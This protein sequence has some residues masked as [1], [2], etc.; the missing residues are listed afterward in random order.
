MS[1]RRASCVPCPREK[2]GK[3]GGKL[4]EGDMHTGVLELVVDALCESGRQRS[5][6]GAIQRQNHIMHTWYFGYN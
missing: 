6:D 1:H 5:T 2:G 4:K 3:D